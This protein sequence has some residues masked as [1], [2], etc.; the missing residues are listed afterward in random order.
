[1]R[2]S[3]NSNS[4]NADFYTQIFFLFSKYD[5][6]YDELIA[7]KWYLLPLKEQKVFVLL[8]NASKKPNNLN[9]ADIM[10]LNVHTYLIVSLHS[11]QLLAD[12]I[13]YVFFQVLQRIYSFAMVLFK[14][15]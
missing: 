1:M 3:W 15:T 2:E 8:L 13:D 11:F 12:I 10:P 4:V 14:A 9:V 5:H 6:F 7:C